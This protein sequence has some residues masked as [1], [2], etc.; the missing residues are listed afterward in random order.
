MTFLNLAVLAVIQGITEFLPVSSSG[1]LILVPMLTDWP[2]QGLLMDVAVHMGTLLAVIL[3]VFKDLIGMASG[4]LRSLKGKSDPGATLFWQMVVATIP[5]VVC[6]YF[7]NSAYPDWFRSLE[8]VAWTTL[9]FGIL[10]YVAD[11]IGMTMKRIEHLQYFDAIVIGLAQILALVPGTSRSGVTMTAGRILGMERGQ[12][13]RFSLILGIPT[14]L[15]AG[16]LKGWELYES[17]NLELT[18]SAGIAASLAFVCAL[19]AIAVMM[20]WLKRSTFTPFVIYRILLGA[21]LLGLSYEWFGL[22]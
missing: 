19:I 14:I 3:Y 13:A 16:L 4:L 1:H 9:G 2:D 11:S 12:A 5:V 22:F 10:L 21:G 6:G 18:A 17:G 15:G 7:L 20:I 8:T